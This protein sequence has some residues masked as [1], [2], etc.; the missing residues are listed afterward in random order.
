MP[1]NILQDV[2]P[3]E[4]RSIRDIPIPL[5]RKKD[6][7]L[8]GT[9]NKSEEFGTLPPIRSKID[10]IKTPQYRYNTDAPPKENYS[11]KIIWTAGVVVILFVVFLVSLIFSGATVKVTPKDQLV[12]FANTYKAQKDSSTAE[13]TYD[14]VKFSKNKGVIVTASGEEKVERKA[15]GKITIFND[16]IISVCD[17]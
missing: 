2:I 16:H 12:T 6:I 1:K 5:N 13:L 3:P 10:K 9:T 4:K 8:I 7:N 15:S 11:K 17:I 14:V